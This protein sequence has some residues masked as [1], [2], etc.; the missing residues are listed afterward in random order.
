MCRQSF[1][2]LTTDGYRND[3]NTV[4][5]DYTGVGQQVGEQD[6]AAGTTI[7]GP[8]GNSFT[9]N[10]ARPY[11][12]GQSNSLADIAMYYWKNDLRT[13]LA[14]KVSPSSDD[15]AFWQ[16]MTTF[17]VSIGAAGTLDPEIDLPAITAGTKS[18]P[19]FDGQNNTPESIDDLWH[20]AVNG[21]GRFV[22]ATDPD[23]FT[24]ALR[25]ALA[26][27]T[28]RTS[29]YSNVAS[30]SVS[31]DTGAKVFNA[32]YVSG[33][34]T[35]S[36]QAR[37]VTPTGVSPTVAWTASIGTWSG[38]KIFTSELGVGS[39]FPTTTQLAQLTRTGGIFNY[40]VTAAQN[41][42]YIKGDQSLEGPDAPRL[43]KRLSLLGDIIGSSP[44]YV[45][46]TDTLYVGAND[47]MLHAFNAASGQ[48][49][50]AY[51]PSIVNMG[52]LSTLSRGDY[53]HKFFVDGPI[54]VT[55]RL[56]TPGKNLLVG[57]LGKGGKGLFALDVTNPASASSAIF[58]W[59]RAET[60]LFN[61]GLV[62][63]NPILANVRDGT[64]KPGVIVGNGP[65]SLN[66][67]AVLL[68]LNTETGAVIRE[69][70]TGAGDATTP[71]GLSAPVGVYGADGKTLAYAYA[72]DLLGNVWKFDMTSS[73]PTAWTVSKVFT[74]KDASNLAQPISGGLTLAVNPKTNDRWIFFGT[75]RFLTT[76]DADATN[77]NVQSMY[78][79][80]DN[81]TSLSRTDLTGRSFSVTGAT[82]NGFPVRAFQA[83]TPLPATSKGWY[84]DLPG[85]GER[86][87]QNAQVVSTFLIT[88]SMIPTG[89]ACQAD[90]SGFINALDAFTGTSA[91]G[92][93]FDLDGSGS[94]DDAAVGGLPVG[95]VNLENGM[96]TLPNLL[97]GLLVAGGT[98]G[99]GLGSPMTLSPRWDRVSWREVRED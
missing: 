92:S 20:A 74:A 51:I 2:I 71:N 76:S 95:S 11:A 33:Q 82:A 62:L 91:G 97:R 61:M 58:K 50:F 84:V 54:S 16:H 66:D 32:S 86:I 8:G 6:N 59:E 37:A 65:N 85:A 87:V 19:S 77:V 39:T 41:A 38:R 67:R 83:S 14:N 35:G 53:A 47:G 79:F 72:G 56:Q 23:A 70:D 30:N 55:T 68:V 60:P 29:S 80:I 17:A 96:P 27:I 99:A 36:L 52:N 28:V 81:G 5:F 93:Y 69:I 31:L 22:V 78:G 13:D 48:E 90:G 57:A 40:P 42:N 1:T 64:S 15:P 25:D 21:R 89:D 44:A 45:L 43:R 94:T 18:W 98:G 88:A 10:P 46:D 49:L 12:F 75:G 63:G 7:T 24:K 4:G 9:Y 3:S 26:A 34:W 73:S